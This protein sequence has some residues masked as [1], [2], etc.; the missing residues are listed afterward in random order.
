MLVSPPLYA[1]QIYVDQTATGNND[2]SSWADAFISVQTAVNVAVAGD[3]IY[4]AQGTYQEGAEITISQPINMFG[5]Y[6]T[7]GGLQDIENNSTTLDGAHSH[8]VIKATHSTGT[9]FLEGIT[10]QNGWVEEEFAKG[11]GIH[12]NRD[13]ILQQVIVI[14]NTKVN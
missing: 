3:D 2:G 11:A 9:L 8:R 13:L 12:S 10:I 7:G 4:I 6:P 14:K 1:A 5:G